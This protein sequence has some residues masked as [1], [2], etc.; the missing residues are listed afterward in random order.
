MKRF[1][2]FGL[3]FTLLFSLG[4]SAEPCWQQ[5]SV[6][7]ADGNLCILI[8]D[9]VEPDQPK[10][11]FGRAA[12]D[13]SETDQADGK[14]KHFCVYEVKSE[15]GYDIRR[16]NDY[17]WLDA[18]ESEVQSRFQILPKHKNDPLSPDQSDKWVLSSGALADLFKFCSAEKP[19]VVDSSDISMCAKPLQNESIAF[20][21]LSTQA[22][23]KVFDAA[24]G[25]GVL[26]LRLVQAMRKD[27]SYATWI[28]VGWA[29]RN[30]QPFATHT[31]YGPPYSTEYCLLQAMIRGHEYCS[32]DKT[33]HYQTGNL[34]DYDDT[35]DGINDAYL[36]NYPDQPSGKP[37][38]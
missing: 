36:L 2:K 22:K 24:V 19:E 3:P 35:A 4:A 33:G 7:P 21:K 30:G 28:G 1:L 15:G 11:F 10:W 17:F 38:L 37:E 6:L 32:V 29:V 9:K 5:Q 25:E 12:L 18:T 27:M 20:G 23:C 14:I 31:V 16:S 8:D 34:I 13:L 26:P